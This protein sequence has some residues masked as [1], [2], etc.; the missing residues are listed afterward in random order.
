MRISIIGLGW[1]GKPLAMYLKAKGFEVRGS[2]TSEEKCA[3][4][5]SD[6][7]DCCLLKMSPH[8]E[9]KDF[10]KLFDTDV[11]IINIPPRRRAQSDT[12]HPEQVKYLKALINQANVKRV[13]Y[14]SATSVYPELNKEV[15]EEEILT[16]EN[17]SNP[18]LFDAEQLLWRGKTY[19]LTVIRFGGLL[20]MERVPGR[21]FSNKEN[22]AGDLPVNYIHQTDAVRLID[23]I[24]VNGMW[25]ETFNGV[26]PMH[27]SKR[28]IYE[29]N[30][31]DFRIAPPKSYRD[32]SDKSWKQV[33]SSKIQS[34]GFKF[35]YNNPLL[36]DYSPF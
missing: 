29:K 14:I 32:T 35:V 30:F 16:K 21:Y 5:K 6:G 18:A 11:L 2:V 20:G 8:P 10:N 9:G 25:N 1:L 13:I 28:E 31:K 19:D 4:L 34:S 26:S 23:F 17:T 24:I 27:P 7:L 3:K 33:T 15:G 36:F 12:F 22:V